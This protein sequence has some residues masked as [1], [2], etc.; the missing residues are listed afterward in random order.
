LRFSISSQRLVC[1]RLQGF[2]VRVSRNLSQ[3]YGPQSH[4]H[5]L[6]NKKHTST[7]STM[8]LGGI[9]DKVSVYEISGVQ[10]DRPKGK[11]RTTPIRARGNGH[12][13]TRQ[14]QRREG[15]GPCLA[16]AAHLSLFPACRSWGFAAMRWTER[17]PSQ[18]A[19]CSAE[20]ASSNLL[21]LRFHECVADGDSDNGPSAGPRCQAG[22]AAR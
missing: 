12:R 4:G 21:C 16:D 6:P 5:A 10:R 17:A 3:G 8:S 18:Y 7:T 20:V 9:A 22:S 19:A 1:R 11:Q 15:K 14:A 2:G 13:F